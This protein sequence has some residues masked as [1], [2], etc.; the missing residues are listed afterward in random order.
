MFKNQ[1]EKQIKNFNYEDIIRYK[2]ERGNKINVK[3]ARRYDSWFPS[4]TDSGASWLKYGYIEF[5]GSKY[6]CIMTSFSRRRVEKE[7]S[8]IKQIIEDG[9]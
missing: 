5:E 2:V 1:K 3:K 4:Q 9:K 8:K 7:L 6:V